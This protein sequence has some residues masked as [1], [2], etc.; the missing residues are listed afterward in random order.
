M[1]VAPKL[2]FLFKDAD[3]FATAISD[4]LQ[5][6]P[7]SNLRRLEDSFELSLERYG[8]KDRKASGNIV[9][10]MDSD[11][12]YQ[13]TLLLM[14]NY[15]PPILV[16]AISEVL[17]SIKGESSSIMPTIVLPI[18]VPAQ[19]LKLEGKHSK[20]SKKVSL[21]GLQTG[22]ETD[23]TQSIVAKTQNPPLSLQIHHEPL[24]CFLQLVRVSKLPTCVL[25]GQSG[26]HQLQKNLREE[27]EMIYEMG[28]LLTSISSMTFLRERIAWNPA[29]SSKDGEEPWRALYG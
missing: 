10:F 13:V 24:A 20:T 6:N 16:C 21:Y 9:Q 27:L 14:E 17:A 5:P 7:N 26:Q 12:N 25:I 18:M 1:K 4:A 19:K 15:E 8:I 2:I 28:E 3:G 11:G 22:Q 23:M 29:K